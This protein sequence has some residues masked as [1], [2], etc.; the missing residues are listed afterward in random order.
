MCKNKIM[1]S[2]IMV[3][4]VIYSVVLYRQYT[5][6]VRVNEELKATIKEER[7]VHFEVQIMAENKFT[8]LGKQY[9]K[10][11]SENKE[12]ENENK[13]LKLEL[14][15]VEI[16]KYKYSEKEVMLLAKCVQAEAGVTNYK[17]QKL[18]TKVI[19]NRV[20]STKFP[21][22]ITK[23]IYQKNGKIPQF[24]VAYN[25]ALD[26]QKVT[27]K[28]LANV[29][30]VLLYGCDMPKNVLFFYASSL[31]ENNWVKSLRI[32][33]EVEGTIFSYSN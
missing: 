27:S 19:L 3:I 22:S 13:D 26:K 32:Y 5:E 9:D 16:P 14:K 2:V 1:I 15:R 20:E 24:S 8:V 30:S 29:Q 33:K 21:N 7:E 10:V 31:R 11:Q 17:S 6:V 25:G 4:T 23:V 28:T 12:L 18:V